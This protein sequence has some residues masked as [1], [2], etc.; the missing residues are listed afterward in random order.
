MP[1]RKDDPTILDDDLLWRRIVNN[2]HMVKI[3]P[4]GKIRPSSAVFLDGYTGEVSV[5]L[6]R[7][8][9]FEKIRLDKPDVGVV[10]INAGYP[11]SLGQTI[12]ADPTENDPSHTLICPPDKPTKKRKIDARLMAERSQWRL[13]PKEYR[14]E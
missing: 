9:N 10:E 11:R 4:D 2:P 5:H 14:T 8:T 13:F 12:V 3:E 1:Q 7:L 6:A